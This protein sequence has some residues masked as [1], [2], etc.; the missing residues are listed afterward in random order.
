MV[1]V[2]DEVQQ[3]VHDDAIELIRKL[4]PVKSGILPHGIYGDEK[5]SGEAVSLAVIEGDDIG[6]I[7]VLQIFYIDIQYIIIG[8]EYYRNVS[9]T[10][11]LASP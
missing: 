11:G 2:A 1:I 10:F 3:A 6:I 8:T 9:E 4:R 5:V 7:I